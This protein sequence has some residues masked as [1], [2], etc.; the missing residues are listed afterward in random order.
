MTQKQSPKQSTWLF[1]VHACLKALENPHR[2]VHQCFVVPIVYEKHAAVLRTCSNITQVDKAFFH[3][4][5][6]TIV[7]QGIALEVAPLSAQTLHDLAL[8]KQETAIVVVLDHITDPHNIGA[9]LRASAAF[10]VHA[11]ITTER[12]APQDEGTV[13]KVASGALDVVPF[14]KEVN[15]VRTLE[16][17]KSQGFWIYGL[18]EQ[19]EI[20]SRRSDFSGKVAIVMGAEGKGLR[21]LTKE[22]CD[23][24]IA[25]PTAHTFT[26]LNV[27][28][29]TAVTLYEVYQQLY[30]RQDV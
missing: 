17:L 3:E 15:L 29:A 19:G 7:H 24:L 23:H 30:K 11:V 28:T 6:P 10:G 8:Q 26:T 18:D 21:R 1:G 12:H 2:E 4:R 14:I 25:L 16:D 5:F 13:A 9:V 22:H 20:L 27:A